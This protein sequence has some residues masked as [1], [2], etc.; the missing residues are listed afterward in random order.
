MGMRLAE[1]NGHEYNAKLN[2][3]RG[4]REDDKVTY[5]DWQEI[6]RAVNGGDENFEQARRYVGDVIALSDRQ[7]MVVA[8]RYF[9]D[10]P[11]PVRR[12]AVAMRVQIGRAHV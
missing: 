12:I 9:L 5:P 4:I 1:Q 3:H 2:N 6:E 11:M 8:A 7:R 10:P